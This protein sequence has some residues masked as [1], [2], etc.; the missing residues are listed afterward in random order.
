MRVRNFLWWFWPLSVHRCG[1]YV[2]QGVGADSH[3][4]ALRKNCRFNYSEFLWSLFLF[5]ISEDISL[6]FCHL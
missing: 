1:S 3:E 4:H 2:R 5:L 6:F